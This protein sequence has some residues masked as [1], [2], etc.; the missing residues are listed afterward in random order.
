MQSSPKPRSSLMRLPYRSGSSSALS[1]T[2]APTNNRGASAGRAGALESTASATRDS[3]SAPS[4]RVTSRPM[5]LETA[6][7][8]VIPTSASTSQHSPSAHRQPSLGRAAQSSQGLIER[9]PRQPFR[10]SS[11]SRTLLA[12]EQSKS[13][14]PQL[15]FTTDPTLDYE[16]VELLGEG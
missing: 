13:R 15:I 2:A 7:S 4:P 6:P 11:S 5:S 8:V 3:R 1:Q 14:H 10:S 12:R 9:S 16:L